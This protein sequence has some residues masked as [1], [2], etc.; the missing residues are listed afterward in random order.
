[1]RQILDQIFGVL[2]Q[3]GHALVTAEAVLV[4]ASAILGAIAMFLVLNYLFEVVAGWR[5]FEKA[6]ERGWKSLIPV[7][8]NYIRY[9]LA[10][11]PLWF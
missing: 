6:G 7:Y 11:R 10:W 1:M 9:R 2:G 8:N 4:I 5:I 3:V